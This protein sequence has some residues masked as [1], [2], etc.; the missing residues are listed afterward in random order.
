M[1]TISYRNGI[2]AADSQ[3]SGSHI[4][5]AYKKIYQLPNGGAFAI[6]SSS[7]FVGAE[8]VDWLTSRCSLRSKPNLVD[9]NPDHRTTVLIVDMDR[10]VYLMDERCGPWVEILGEFVA[11]G[12]GS[13]IA[14]GAMAAGASAVEA[15]AIAAKYDENTG[16][17]VE[18]YVIPSCN[19]ATIGVR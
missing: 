17:P 18:Q 7:S 16:L 15:V 9:T 19:A 5:T 3:L 11:I 6:A 1:T 4:R 12:S 14:I 10:R 8:I 13:G 2:I